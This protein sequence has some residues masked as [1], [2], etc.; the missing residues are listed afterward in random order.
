MPVT[1]TN[2]DAIQLNGSTTVHY[3]EAMRGGMGDV[4]FGGSFRSGLSLNPV[5]GTSSTTSASA[6]STTAASTGDFDDE[7]LVPAGRDPETHFRQLGFSQTQARRLAD[8]PTH[9][10][11]AMMHEF[12]YRR[13]RTR[14]TMNTIGNVVRDL[15]AGVRDFFR[16]APQAAAPQREVVYQQA[17]PQGMS[18]TTMA[19]IGAAGLAGAFLLMKAAD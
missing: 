8:A 3:S 5:Y 12:G 19:L 16:P 4:G 2:A 15:G 7:H 17:A 1:L 13:E 9:Q 18:T 14:Q 10:R 11:E 6:P